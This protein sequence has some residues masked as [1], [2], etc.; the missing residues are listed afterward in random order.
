MEKGNENTPIDDLDILRK[1][2][3]LEG[4]ASLFPK[5]SSLFPKAED[6]KANPIQ[7]N[8]HVI[9]AKSLRRACPKCSSNNLLLNYDRDR[10]KV[11]RKCMRCS[12]TWEEEPLDKATATSSSGGLGGERV[13]NQIV[14]GIKK[15][16]AWWRSRK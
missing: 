15:I 9:P 8:T 14:E 13:L 12:A 1:G 4:D 7:M 2:S 16:I 3:I 5:D 10:D 6:T 11:I